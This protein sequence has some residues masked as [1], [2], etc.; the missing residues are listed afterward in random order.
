MEEQR[1]IEDEL[2]RELEFNKQHIVSMTDI[3]NYEKSK[4]NADISELQSR[5]KLLLNRLQVWSDK[6][7]NLE[8]EVEK[9]KEALNEK[10]RQLFEKNVLIEQSQNMSMEERDKNLDQLITE[11]NNTQ[12]LHQLVV[13]MRKKN[14]GLL[15]KLKQKEASEETAKQMENELNKSM[16]QKEHLSSK[17][18]ESKTY[19]DHLRQ[20]ILAIKTDYSKKVSALEMQLSETNDYSKSAIDKLKNEYEE[21]LANSARTVEQLASENNE[22]EKEK[23]TS[24]KRLQECLESLRLARAELEL[25]QR[26]MIQ[27]EDRCRKDVE[28][29]ETERSQVLTEYQHKLETIRQLGAE[30]TEIIEHY[31]QQIDSLHM[32]LERLHETDNELKSTKSD[33]SA[34]KKERDGLVLVIA[35]KDDEIEDL[36]ERLSNLNNR[37]KDEKKTLKETKE[38]FKAQKQQV[39]EATQASIYA[40]VMQSIKESDEKLKRAVQDSNKKEVMVKDYRTRVMALESKIEELEGHN[41]AL[42]NKVRELQKRQSASREFQTLGIRYTDMIKKLEEEL[43]VAT[44]TIE[45]KNASIRQYKQR[46]EKMTK[47][48]SGSVAKQKELLQKLEQDLS[49]ANKNIA[50][51][52]KLLV[53]YKS[54]LDRVL[55]DD[56]L[57]NLLVSVASKQIERIQELTI[58]VERMEVVHSLKSQTARPTTSGNINTGDPQQSISLSLLGLTYNEYRDIMSCT[59]VHD[60]VRSLPVREERP[61]SSES[62]ELFEAFIN[63]M[64]EKSTTVDEMRR[65]FDNILQSRIHL[66][67]RAARDNGDVL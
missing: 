25:S 12:R 39:I 57:K 28:A 4:Q 15:V 23:K 60:D 40:E 2:R 29:I 6:C 32:D 13:E 51:K 37:L 42:A 14:D 19:I 49:T 1:K 8:K 67:L 27:M 21:R 22:L 9:L 41:T 34:M 59:E 52:N 3:L 26:N 58:Q 17:L 53:T 65:H 20:E 50:E 62:I 24:N 44:K 38:N 36:R 43:Q 11:Q 10:D 61:S 46:L 5:E 56:R 63:A 30:K 16:E 7:T 55:N 66:E 45:E 31:Q 33:L 54:K 47:D 48:E 18:R 64:K 35:Q